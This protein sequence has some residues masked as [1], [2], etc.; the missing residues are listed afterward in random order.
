[1]SKWLEQQ[2]TRELT[3][4]KAPEE[5]WSRV[6]EACDGQQRRGRSPAVLAA[7]AAML[8][9]TAG[10]VWLWANPGR[11]VPPPVTAHGACYACHA[12]L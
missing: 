11:R 6:D 7:A 5:L 10:S 8:L 1:M 4:M 12:S 2:L 9:I 3:P